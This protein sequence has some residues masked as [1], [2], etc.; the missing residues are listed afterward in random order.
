MKVHETRSQANADQHDESSKIMT[1]K[2]KAEQTKAHESENSSKKPKQEDHDTDGKAKAKGKQQEEDKSGSRSDEKK[3]MTEDVIQEYEE[4]SAAVREH[5][6][7]Q[8][9]REILEA[10]DQNPS[11]PA[12][13]VILKCID[14][15]F[16]GPLE[17]CCLCGGHLEFNASSYTCDGTYNEWSS[18]TYKAREPP[19]KKEAT[20]LPDSVQN[21]P[22][23]DLLRKYQDPERPRPQREAPPPGKPFMGMMISLSGHLSKTHGDWKREIEKHGG[24][25]SNSVIGANCLVV[26]PMEREHGGSS[27]VV[28][29]LERGVPVVRE[30][31]LIDSIKKQEVQS[32]DAYDCVSDL[33]VYGRGIP[34]DKQDPNGEALE[35]I[36]AELKMYGKRAVHKDSTLQ[37]QDG[38]ILERDGIL[39]NCAFALCDQGHGINEIAIMQLITVPEK[40]LHLFYKKGRLGDDAR[41]EERVEEWEDEGA[42][43][44]EFVRLFEELTGNEFE[45]WEREKKSEKKPRKF[46]PIDMDDGYDARYGGLS[47]RQLGAA[48]VH[49][50]LEPMVG[51]FMKILCSQEPY[52]YALMEMGYDPPDLP[53]GMLTNFHLER[54]KEILEKHVEMLKSKEGDPKVE[55]LWSD[56]SQRWFTIMPSTRPFIF[57]NFKQVADNAAAAFEAVRDITAASHLIGDMTGS[58]LDDPLYDRYE[59]LGCS[60]KLVEKESEDY[61]MIQKY[62][63]TTYE[64]FKVGEISYG[65]T[66]ENVFAVNSTAGPSYDELKKLPNKVLLWCGTRSSNLLRHLQKGFLP[67]VCSLPAPGYVFGR[68]IIC[69]DAAAE[70]ARYGFTAVDRPEGLL[71]LAVAALGEEIIELNS[72]PKDTKSLEARKVG[73]KGVGKKTTYESEH[74]MW[75]DDIKVPCG[76]LIPTEKN[77]DMLEYNEYAVYDPKQ[78][79]IR[80]LVAVKYEEMD[81]EYDEAEP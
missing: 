47:L 24:K 77:I 30:A 69:S 48:A 17:K 43:L 33:R 22:I 44:K 3:P 31:W 18:C 61:K 54:C 55:A 25:V 73:V 80:F 8:Q 34:W 10:N 9:M 72:P 7:A 75:K 32:L 53:M 42:A 2:Q 15:L 4:L 70:A 71:V 63:E 38:K 78:A 19:R 36:S 5:L 58:T 65:A 67:A 40:N 60:I 74:F 45:P 59:K 46:Y 11:G 39:Y 66:I 81:V 52:R 29:A 56:F 37:Q 49:T 14:L 68:A 6:S 76:R 13:S 51:N 23:K 21:S 26:S 57:K 62:L 16:Y 12:S 79:S 27:K 35:S 28:E 50:K 41:A 64:P 1:R 20:K